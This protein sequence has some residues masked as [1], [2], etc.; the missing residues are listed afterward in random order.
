M[1][2]NIN[3]LISQLSQKLGTS[4][5]QLSDAAKNGDVSGILKNSN[6]PQAAEVSRVL[7]D[8]EQTKKLLQSPQAQALMK[9]LGGEK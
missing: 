3:K 4:P 5:E 8:P 7:N 1:S 9:M 6:N 2:E